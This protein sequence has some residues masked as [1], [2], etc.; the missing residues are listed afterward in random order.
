MRRCATGQEVDTEMAK[1]GPTLTHMSDAEIMKR[2]KA[3]DEDAMRA[4]L[5]R[6]G[7]TVID[8]LTKRH[9]YHVAAEAMNDTA[10][11]IWTDLATKYEEG[12]GSLLAWF[13]QIANHKALDIIR[14]EKREKFI[15]LDIDND[16]DPTK[17][18]DPDYED[19]KSESF[20]RRMEKS[21]AVRK[22]INGLSRKERVVIECDRDSRHDIA[23]IEEIRADLGDPNASR[24][25]IETARCRARATLR[26]EMIRL[27]Y[28]P[29][30]AR[31]R[32]NG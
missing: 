12:K 14:G 17:C 15:E 9:G 32:K 22:T 2:V 25:S 28:Y 10:M 8:I 23:D 30:D 18:R 29:A 16:Y 5:A 4:L 6:H 27:G 26:A 3:S 31:R 7:Q 11:L 20:Q 19:E 13:L 1:P 21:E 24:G